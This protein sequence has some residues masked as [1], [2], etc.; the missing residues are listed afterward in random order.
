[1]LLLVL[2]LFAMEMKT[3]GNKIN[4]SSTLGEEI[5]KNDFP[6]GIYIIKTISGD[7]RSFKK[8]FIQH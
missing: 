2:C 5:I 1:M 3:Y 4:T 7:D 6:E 8:I